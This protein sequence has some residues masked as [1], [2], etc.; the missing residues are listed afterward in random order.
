[1]QPEGYPYVFVPTA[2]YDHIQNV[3]R[4]RGK[5]TLEDARL[6]VIDNFKRSFDKILR[7]AGVKKWCRSF[8]RQK[9]G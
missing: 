9:N 3:F 2:R 4:P 5:W 8:L 7:K 1:M 6:K